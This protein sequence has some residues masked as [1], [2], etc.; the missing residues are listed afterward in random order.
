MIFCC[1]SMQ[2]FSFCN[3]LFVTDLETAQMLRQNTVS[4]IL[5]LAKDLAGHWSEWV[6]DFEKLIVSITC[7]GW[8]FVYALP[9]MDAAVWETE[10]R[11]MQ[12]AVNEDWIFEFV[13][14]FSLI[15]QG[16][17]SGSTTILWKTQRTSVFF[18]WI[19][20]IYKIFLNS[21]SL[22]WVLHEQL[23]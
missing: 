14:C 16:F 20:I 5:I 22:L 1:F 13:I 7:A 9:N 3:C 12:V 2:K 6:F 8:N 19:I 11:N 17:P 18:A 21:S 4:I 15:A 23:F 10:G